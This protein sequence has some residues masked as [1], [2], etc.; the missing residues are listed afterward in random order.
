MD[1]NTNKLP[2]LNFVKYF[3]PVQL[4][5]GH[6]KY[7]LLAILYWL[8][9][10]LIVTD[11]IGKAY[12]VPL[13]FFSPEYL[14][15][16]NNWS[17]LFIGF[18]VGGFIMGFNTYSYIKL[19]PYYPFLVVVTK[20]FLKFCLNNFIIPL[21]FNIIYIYN[22]TYFQLNEEHATGGQ[23][24]IYILSYIGG[25]TI[26]LLLSL[27]YFFPTNKNPFS[28]IKNGTNDGSQSSK[29]I[30]SVIHNKEKW[31][32]AFQQHDEKSYIYIGT[33]F[34]L[35]KS[36]TV[37]HLDEELI[38]KVF[39]KNRVN[40]SV[41]ELIT[42]ISFFI[43][44]GFRD[45]NFFNMPAAMSFILLLTIILMLFSA[46]LSWF[47]RWTYPI[48]ICC[49]M[50]MNYLSVNT[51]FFNYKN[52]AYGLNYS[53][54]NRQDYSIEKIEESINSENTEQ[55]SLHSYIKI[56][57]KWKENTGED[58]PKLVLINTSGGGSRSALWTLTV[59]QKT[60][61]QL[62]G[63]LFKHTQLITGASGG[64]VG[65][66]Y[67]REILL[68]YKKGEINNLYSGIYRQ[69]IAKDMLN[70]LFFTASTN[71]M[72]FRYQK[73]KINGYTYPKDRGYSFEQQLHEN[74]DNVLN[75]S[76]G[77]YKYYEKNAMIPV[78]IFNPTII[79]DGRRL[80]ISSQPLSFITESGGGPTNMARS[81]ENIDYLN[82]FQNNH[83]NDIRFS[84]VVRI[85]ATF[86]FILPMVTLPTKP[87]MQLMDSGIR[88]NYGGKSMMEFL[89]VMQDWI[90]ENTSGVV[91]I[92]VRDTKKVLKDEVYHQV[93]LG[94]K[95]SLPFDNM[96]RNFTRT[97][98][99]DQE[100]LMKIGVNNLKFPVNLIS[101]NLR[102]NK[103]DRISLSWHL[104]KDEKQKIE[105]AYMSIQNQA[106][107]KELNRLLH[108]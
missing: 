33:K 86:P 7:N 24:F 43:L 83:P 107:L 29:P 67:F 90:K 53:P 16:V 25:I 60:D 69:N 32:D 52:Y 88:D 59:L 41:F 31:Y 100:E 26:F 70:K 103:R 57:N 62:K 105:K 93:S 87:E 19:G 92:Q 51:S 94:D 85:Q 28:L 21:I 79:N 54:N 64:M 30:N 22:L 104:T 1:M 49:F 17:F 102:E 80:L 36:R 63:Q 3:F 27:L 48:M 5:I 18:S 8:I 75:H 68:R 14:G 65:A 46:L 11:N 47:H 84:T 15:E 38:E 10:L 2:I 78:M 42:I 89:H 50:G 45:Y 101:F 71:D 20:P 34:K 73:I 96:Y 56:L 35:F 98:D 72:F 4:F 66:A 37:Q 55:K 12:G 40:T 106:A 81:Y 58:K 13:L 82:F 39:A 9:L 77:Y 76:L 95:L 44:G 97:Q 91:I 61:E 99:F 74:T 108:E 23:V 6:L